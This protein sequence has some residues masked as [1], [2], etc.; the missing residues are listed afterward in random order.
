M[1][2]IFLGRGGRLKEPL[3]QP[4]RIGVIDDER[5]VFRAYEAFL[6]TVIDE[7]DEGI[8]IAFGVEDADRLSVK[9]KLCPGQNLKELF[10]GAIAPGKCDEAISKLGHP[11]FAGVHGVDNLKARSAQ[12]LDAHSGDLPAHQGFGDDPNHFTASLKGCAREFSHQ[13][14]IAAAIDQAQPPLRQAAPEVF[15][16]V[17]VSRAAPEACAE[18][19]AEAMSRAGRWV[20]GGH[21][22]VGEGSHVRAG[23]RIPWQAVGASERVPQNN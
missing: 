10:E 5:P 2:P 19:D 7:V 3:D 12:V 23:A 9:A 4:V 13:A 22:A 16:S 6:K 15:G 1:K 14:D 17:L 8:K 21:V 20:G 11:G 18:K